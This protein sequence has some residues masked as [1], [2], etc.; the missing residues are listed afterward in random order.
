LGHKTYGTGKKKEKDLGDPGS[1]INQAKC[2]TFFVVQ[3]SLLVIPNKI[4]K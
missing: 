1:G 3:K 2:W 4:I